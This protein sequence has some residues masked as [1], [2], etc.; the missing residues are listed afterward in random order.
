MLATG[1]PTGALGGL[2]TWGTDGLVSTRSATYSLYDTF[3]ERGGLAQRLSAAGG[4]YTTDKF[5]AFGSRTSTAIP[6]DGWGFKAQWGYFTDKETGLVHMRP[7]LLRP[8]NGQV[9]DAGPH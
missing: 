1:Q 5:D 8:R 2:N 3:D 7:P 9:A 6:S 4:V